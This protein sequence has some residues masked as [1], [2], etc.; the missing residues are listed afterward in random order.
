MNTGHK[1][2]IAEDDAS[3][4]L[5]LQ[6]VLEKWGYEVIAVADGDRALEIL[7][8]DERPALAVLDWMMPG[9]D[10]VEVCRRLRALGLDDP[11]Y[12]I[13]LTSRAD[14]HDVATGL[15]AGADD[16]VLKPFDRDELRARLLVG[17]RFVE[18]NRSLLEAK[19]AL[20]RQAVTDSLTGVLNR[21]GILAKL[22]AE[23]A[24][25]ERQGQP[26]S[27][28]LLDIDHFKAINDRYGHAA[29]DAVLCAVVDRAQAAL[30]SYDSLGRFGGEEFL[31]VLPGLEVARAWPVLERVRL[32]V[33]DGPVRVESQIIPVTVSLGGAAYQG[34][35]VDALVRTADEALYRAKAQGR[36]QTVMTAD[37]QIAGVAVAV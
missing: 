29:G 20:E 35:S 14:K 15:E 18:L 12:V 21:R 27:V 32:R 13:L 17:R 1:V 16:Y 23:L 9:L 2:L 37:D 22:E 7:T 25:S 3:S 5:L 11:P 4:R 28:G 19:A 34:G 26:L 6:K 36:N 8:Q 30:R 24:R 10:G 31:I 33:A